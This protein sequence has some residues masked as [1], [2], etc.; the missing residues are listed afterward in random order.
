MTEKQ[1]LCLRF[2]GMIGSVVEVSHCGL[3]TFWCMMIWLLLFRWSK[4][5]MLL[6][7]YYGLLDKGYRF[8]L[9]HMNSRIVYYSHIICFDRKYHFAFSPNHI[10]NFSLYNFC[11]CLF[12]L[13]FYGNDTHRQWE[14]TWWQF[15]QK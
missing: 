11:F 6:F 2:N 12:F 8:K 7:L 5:V 10:L 14:L 3:W 15:K 13:A 9:K 4:M 1:K